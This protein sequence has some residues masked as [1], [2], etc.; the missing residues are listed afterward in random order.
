M[1]S[2]KRTLSPVQFDGHLH[3]AQSQQVRP[4]NK[5]YLP[6]QLVAGVVR[7]RQDDVASAGKMWI[8]LVGEQNEDIPFHF[9]ITAASKTQPDY[10]S[11]DALDISSV[12]VNFRLWQ[13][14]RIVAK[15]FV[16]DQPTVRYSS[17]T[18]NA[19]DGKQVEKDFSAQVRATWS[20]KWVY[21]KESDLWESTKTMVGCFRVGMLPSFVNGGLSTKYGLKAEL[22]LPNTK[23]KQAFSLMQPAISSGFR[24][25]VLPVYDEEDTIVPPAYWEIEVL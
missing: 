18:A 19:V 12:A 1:Q 9:T 15:G 24:R 7:I 23:S 3:D 20:S 22:S 6:G 8:E 21:M 17:A 16:E 25:D 13:N 11:P 5:I 14:I 2:I 4:R 10:N